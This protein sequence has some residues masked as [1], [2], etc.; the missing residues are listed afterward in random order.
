MAAAPLVNGLH[1]VTVLAGD[2]R[3]NLAFYGGILGLRL[4]KK[5]VNFDAPQVYHLYYGD[6]KGLP[7]SILTF[8]PYGSMYRGT[9]GSGMA[10]GLSFSVPAGSRTAWESRLK[11]F[12]VSF[13]PA[14]N[15][16]PGESAIAFEDHDGLALQLVFNDADARPG[17][18]RGPL[19]AE[20]AIRGLFGVEIAEDSPD[21]SA[22]FL[23][24]ALDHAAIGEGGGRFRY[25]ASNLPGHYV[26]LVTAGGRERH[27][28]QGRGSVHHVAFATRDRQ[29]Q[30]M[31]R[32]RLL[33]GTVP[34]HPTPPIDR[35]Y[36]V[37]V[38]FHEPG[39]VL[40]EI[41]TVGPGFGVDEPWDSLGS[42][43]K[44]PPQYEPDRAALETV[45][46]P[47][48]LAVEDYR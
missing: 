36:F 10:T 46:V 30:S 9:S 3:Q 8:F 43:L 41:A 32:A 35:Q 15:R 16:L 29:A 34:V 20:H 25:A 5:T 4:V 14:A 17:H 19:P 23:V 11:R 28:R 42:A 1:H 38:Y 44:L 48:S 37:S 13:A 7:G 6:E 12:G 31:A 21:E 18:D 27:G 40:F 47:L 24:D 39:G 45:L 26:D 22:R 2:P 33:A